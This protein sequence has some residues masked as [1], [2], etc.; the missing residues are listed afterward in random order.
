VPPLETLQVPIPA[1]I[2][3][4]AGLTEITGREDLTNHAVRKDVYVDFLPGK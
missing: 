3:K 4:R 2:R 1:K